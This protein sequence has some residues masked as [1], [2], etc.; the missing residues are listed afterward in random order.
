[1]MMMVM[2]IEQK[3]IYQ[4]LRDYSHAENK[5]AKSSHAKKVKRSFV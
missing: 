2:T 5:H 4:Y 1:M 3:D